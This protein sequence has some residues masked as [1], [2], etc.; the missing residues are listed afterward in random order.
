[1]HSGSLVINLAR[2]GNIEFKYLNGNLDQNTVH[3]RSHQEI[4]Q[5][6][7]KH[8]E[9]QTFTKMDM[10]IVVELVWTCRSQIYI[11]NNLTI[12]KTQESIDL[13]FV[14]I[15]SFPDFSGYGT[16][17]SKPNTYPRST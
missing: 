9:H 13:G 4:F 5:K 7:E 17:F 8:E 1:M 6:I 16:L 14:L 2:E 15:N 11:P 12:P 10:A 3:H